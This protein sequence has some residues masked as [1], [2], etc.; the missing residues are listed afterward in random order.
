MPASHRQVFTWSY[1]QW[2]DFR[3]SS[4]G[5]AVIQSVHSLGVEKERIEKLVKQ[6]RM[7][8]P[9]ST[10]GYVNTMQQSIFSPVFH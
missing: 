8:P 1:Q 4:V 3:P 2:N 6:V 10:K 7:I 5:S 9:E